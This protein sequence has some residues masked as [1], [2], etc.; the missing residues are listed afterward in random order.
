MHKEI[1]LNN[2]DHLQLLFDQ[3]IKREKGTANTSQLFIKLSSFI[4]ANE[5]RDFL[6]QNEY[7]L[8]LV[9]TR[10]KRPFLKKEF[11]HLGSD[12]EFDFSEV[13]VE[14]FSPS[15]LFQNDDIG[16]TPVKVTLVQLPETSGILFQFNHIY[17]DN[18]GV[19]NLLRSFNGE[20][21]DFH[22]SQAIEQDKFYPRLKN[23]LQFAKLMLTNWTA[24]ISNLSANK[25]EI[26][27][28]N[29]IIQNFTREDTEIIKSRIKRSFH[30]QSMSSLLLAAC[31]K[32]IQDLLIQQGKKIH[33]FTFQQPFELISKKEPAYIIGNR[34]SFLH[35]KLQPEE[36]NTVSELQNE[37]NKQ[38]MQQMKDRIAYKSM[39]F[40]SIIRFL[41]H[42]VHLAMIHLP[43][44]AKMTS[45]AYT[46]I[47]EAKI[48]D[49]FANREILDMIHIPPVMKNPP[50][51]IGGMYYDSNLRIEVCYDQ[52][53]INKED[54][55]FINSRILHHLISEE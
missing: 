1:S 8:Q 53:S 2:S 18:N 34:F 23:A 33:K 19:K 14:L 50:I 37:I 49:S 10:V 20:K 13:K 6:I 12:M 11:Y 9:N 40:E 27:K 30:I 36:V 39:D 45:F 24:P 55:D 42:R 7:F 46:F 22:R 4:S 25:G 43:A 51:T 17:I 3:K 44:R 5:L 26:V 21:F 15:A 54:A 16:I 48:I 28:K 35:Y 47:G 32:A 31:C 29:Y 52:N 41:N 38:T